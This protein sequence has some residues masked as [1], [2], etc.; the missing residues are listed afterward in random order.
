MPEKAKLLLHSNAPWTGTGYGTQCAQFAPRLAQEYDLAISAFYGLEGNVIPWNGIPVLPGIGQTYGNETIQEHARMFLGD[1]LRSGLVMTLEDCWVLDPHIWSGLNC[2]SWVP[3]DH[4]PCPRPVRQFFENSGS[5]P[6]AMS[7]FGEKML[8]GL[9]P[10]Y[11]PHG[12]DTATLKPQDKTEAREA[13]GLPTDAYVVGMVAAN[14]GNPSR[15]CFQEAFEAFA[16]FHQKHPDSMLYLHTEQS[17]RFQ[18]VNIP[19]L[20]TACGVPLK[21]AVLCDQYRAVHYPFDNEHMARVFNSLDVL[22]SPSAGEGF[23]LAVIEAQACG[24]PVIV[25][26]FSAQPELVGAGWL[27]EGVKWFTPIGSWQFKPSVPDILNAL[28]S[29]FRNHGNELYAKKAR[30]KSL[31]YSVDRVFKD[32]MLPA[33]VEAQKRFDARRPVEL[34]A[35]A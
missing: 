5:I 35:A 8:E 9:D 13:L 30:D 32:Y 2:L 21:A 12:V 26:D 16:Q 25:S 4:E 31:E 27:V 1:D 7:R 22:L 20:L 23:G 11:C 19:E 6:L 24:V 3:V 33:L 29:A 28:N 34:K 10:L 15:K 18:G 17:G 14:K